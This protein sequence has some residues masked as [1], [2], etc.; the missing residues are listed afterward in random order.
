MTSLRKSPFSFSKTSLAAVTAVCILSFLPSSLKV[1]LHTKGSLHW[2]GHTVI[3][4]FLILIFLRSARSDR[5]SHLRIFSA[6]GLGLCLEAAQ[7]LVYA[8]ESF[9]WCDVLADFS[10]VG[11]GLLLWTMREHL[12]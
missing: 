9:E 1:V 5:S 12:R 11:L 3:F 8:G 2:I 6:F 4:F 10:G 7:H